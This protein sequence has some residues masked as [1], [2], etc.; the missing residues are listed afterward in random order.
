ML[1]QE[2]HFEA[3]YISI[4]HHLP[5]HQRLGSFLLPMAGRSGFLALLSTLSSSIHH[6]L[7]CFLPLSHTSSSLP[8]TFLCGTSLL[9]LLLLHSVVW[10]GT[11]WDGLQKKICSLNFHLLLP[12]FSISC[13]MFDGLMTFSNEIRLTAAHAISEERLAG[14]RVAYGGSGECRRKERKEVR[15]RIS[16]CRTA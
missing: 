12:I 5:I 8:A 4:I 16:R 10:N 11:T 15:C 6:P 14:N 13:S 1:L 9:L 3:G 2:R 7:V